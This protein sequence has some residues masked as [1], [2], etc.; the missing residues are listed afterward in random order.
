MN[1]YRII[2]VLL[3]AIFW[4]II[5]FYFGGGPIWIPITIYM[6]KII[7]QSMISISILERVWEHSSTEQFLSF[8]VLFFLVDETVET[9]A[10]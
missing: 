4:I 6:N 9:L 8:F 1:Q 5:D 2:I 10:F 7:G 3:T